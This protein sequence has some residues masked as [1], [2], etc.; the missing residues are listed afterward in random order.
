MLKD[1]YDS[2]LST[3]SAAARDAYV[4]GVDQFLAARAGADTALEEAVAHD[5]GFAMGHLALARVHQTFGRGTEARTALARARAAAAS[6]REATQIHALGL[7]IEG[8]GAEAYKVIRDHLAEHPRDVLLAQTCTGVFGLIGFS[9]QPGREAEQLAF[10]AALAPAYGEDWWFLAQHAFSQT[11]AGQTGPAAGTIE[12]SLA[13]HPGNANGAHIKAH[14]HYETGE[15]AG[16]YAYLDAWRDGYEKEGQLHCHISWHIAL[17]ALERGDT[18]RMWHVIDADVAPGGAWGPAI[19]VLTDLASILYRAEL[20]GVAVP[21]EKWRVVSDFAAGS[22]P[23]TGLAFA[24]THAALAH[25]IAGSAEALERLLTDPRG[26]A[27]DVVAALG[28]AFRHLAAQNWE[29]A[30]RQLSTAMADHARIGGSR[31]QRDLLE[32]ALAGA[33]LRLGRGEEARRLLTMRRPVSARTAPIAG[34]PA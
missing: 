7:L 3:G 10:T 18:E 28:E 6:A 12:R 25:S 9:G 34:L 15:A 31:A 23:E 13:L 2:P 11:E 16:G 4:T 27:G 26:P 8:R 33:L 5:P 14:L 22:F 24:D 1:R 21:A 30:V 17:W 20:A 29:A 32:F 19:N